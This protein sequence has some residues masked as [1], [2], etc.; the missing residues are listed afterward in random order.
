MTY[1][2]GYEIQGKKPKLIEKPTVPTI[3]EPFPDASYRIRWQGSTGAYGYDFQRAESPNGP[4]ITI[5]VDVS[6][7]YPYA[8]TMFKDKFNPTPGKTYY[9]RIRAKSIGG[10]SDWSKPVA[11]TIPNKK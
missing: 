3:I 10:F 5:G 6:D 9:Y 4:W 1:L 8:T 2:K 7:D 11:C